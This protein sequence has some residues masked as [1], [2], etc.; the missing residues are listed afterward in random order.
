[1]SPVEKWQIKKTG[2]TNS[3]KN[4]GN[5]PQDKRERKIKSTRKLQT[6]NKTSKE[7]KQPREKQIK[8]YDTNII[9]EVEN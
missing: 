1:M 9:S 5:L 2:T 7:K 3:S 4:N 6:K 8:K